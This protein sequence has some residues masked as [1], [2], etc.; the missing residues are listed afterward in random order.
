MSPSRA[1]TPS[2]ALRYDSG[3]GNGPFG[4]GWVLAG[5][6]SVRRKTERGLPKY[7]QA[8]ESD[9]FVLSDAE[10]LVP[11]LERSDGAWVHRTVTQ[12]GHVVHR[13]RPRVEGAFVRIERWVA[14]ADGATHWRTWSRDNVLSIYGTTTASQIVDPRYPHR[15]FE[16]LLERVQDDRG[17]VTVFRYKAEDLVGVA[18]GA[19]FER[20]RIDEGGQQPQRYLKRILYG[21]RTPAVAEDFAFEVVFDYGEHGPTPGESPAGEL[22]VSHDEVRPWPTR[23]DPFSQCRAGF[24]VRT[25]RVCRR[26]LMFHRFP[27]ELGA[28]QLVASTDFVHTAAT[29]ATML[30]AVV[31]RGYERVD[32]ATPERYR[33]ASWPALSLEY[34]P[35]EIGTAVRDVDAGSLRDVPGQIDGQRVRLVDLDGEGLPGLLVQAAGG[36]YYKRPEGDARFGPARLLPKQPNFARGERWSLTDLDGDGRLAL[37]RM[38]GPTSGAFVREGAVATAVDGWAAFRPFAGRL[39]VDLS[40]P[41]AFVLD[42]TGDGLADVVVFE[43]ERVVLYP[44]LGREGFGKP[45][46]CGRPVGDEREGPRL[47]FGDATRA[48]FLADMGGDGLNDLVRLENGRVVYWPNLGY[49]RFGRMVE[50]GGAPWFDRPD[51]FR[52]DRIRLGD[53]DGSGTADLLY[54]GSEGARVWINASGNRYGDAVAIDGLP[55][56]DGAAAVELADLLGTGCAAVVW[57]T[58]SASLRGTHVKYVDLAP[59][60]KPYLLR[61]I[62]NGMGLRRTL[63]HDTSTRAY[64]QDRAAGEPWLTRVP[65]VV[66]TLSRVVVTEAITQ[67]RFATRYRYRHGHYDGAEREFRG[68]AVVEQ[69]DAESFGH[70]FAAIGGEVVLP[71]GH[72]LRDGDLFV[73]PVLTRTRFHTG[74]WLD[75]DALAEAIARED[76]RADANDPSAVAPVRLPASTLPPG[77]SAGERR[78]AMRALRGRTLRQEVYALALQEDGS[79]LL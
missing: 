51:R 7:D 75:A 56:F 58:N 16:W 17:N 60:G 71:S 48:V 77:L 78:E 65:F 2:L 53:I 27:A 69:T 67:R 25:W 28:P 59:G 22:E 40:A 31:R 34:A 50:M 26:A 20:G 72:Q 19:V 9:V 62:D 54:F 14:T 47:L 57:S 45:V 76:Y 3:A 11:L 1:L 63:E 6:P 73:P 29:V 33:S 30:T 35:L 13:Y 32:G 46:V 36:L 64:L 24:E 4:L 61:A 10:D 15:V 68:F 12:E 43:R 23:E 5:V 38:T 55:A 37:A 39:N 44:S 52:A 21:N 66:H 42:A 79:A 41:N 8:H 49:G 18:A 70:A 74:A